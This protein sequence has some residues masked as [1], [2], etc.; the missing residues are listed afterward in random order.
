[1]I[2]VG[3]TCLRFRFFHLCIF[4][5]FLYFVMGY[6]EMERATPVSSGLF[7]E[8]LLWNGMASSCL[9]PQ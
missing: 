6:W 1:M 2:Q 5:C 8:L 9:H 7:F 3:K 4:E